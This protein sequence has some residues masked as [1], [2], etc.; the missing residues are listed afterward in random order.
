IEPEMFG[1]FTD[2]SEFVRSPDPQPDVQLFWREFPLKSKASDL[3][4]LLDGPPLEA[5]ELV[6]VPRLRATEFLKRTSTAAWAWDDNADRWRSVRTGEIA[7]GMTLMLPRLGGG[8]STRLGWTGIKEDQLPDAPPPGPWDEASPGDAPSAAWISLE[9]HLADA[10]RE[11]GAIAAALGLGGATAL[12][13]RTA[14]LDHDLGKALSAWQQA[15]PGPR[16][17]S[18]NVWAKGP[19]L[20]RIEVAPGQDPSAKVRDLLNSAGIAWQK[21]NRPP[22]ASSSPEALYYQLDRKLYRAR[23]GLTLD[24]LE[25]RLS[26]RSAHMVPFRPGLRHEAASALAL[27]HSYFRA[28]DD[29]PALAIYLAA[30][31][32]GKTRTALHARGKEGQDVCGIPIS[33]PAIPFE[34]GRPMDFSCA[35]DGS[36]GTFTSC[37]NRFRPDSPGWSA[38]IIDLLGPYNGAHSNPHPLALRPAD[39]GHFGPFA[40]AYYEAL[41]VAADVRA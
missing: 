29:L 1:G 39:Q 16:P 24:E 33:S 26:V 20:L 10:G 9:T 37:G 4:N 7:P 23:T 8:Y 6:A 35:A 5:A 32:H 28:G 41:I 36:A 11:A 19:H 34:E 15:L 22:N 18:S 3:N 27:W 17:S 21:A 25:T 14:A 30:A 31:H 12:A 13:L 40:L 38:L 2:V